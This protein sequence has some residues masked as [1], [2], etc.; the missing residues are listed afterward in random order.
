MPSIVVKIEWDNPKNKFWLNADNVA[1]ALHA[2]CKNT[3]FKVTEVSKTGANSQRNR[4]E[5]VNLLRARR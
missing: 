1:L 4:E 3:K 5:G 2:N